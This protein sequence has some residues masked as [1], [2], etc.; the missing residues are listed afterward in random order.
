MNR[1][2]LRGVKHIFQ[3][4]FIQYIKSKSY[5]II[6]AVLIIASIVS[7]PLISIITSK[8]D[9]KKESVDIK[10]ILIVGGDENWIRGFQTI[11]EQ[12][13]LLK[14]VTLV[15]SDET[16]EK[17][18]K[19]MEQTDKRLEY[20]L[21]SVNPIA[22]S[23]EVIYSNVLKEDGV[24]VYDVLMMD[25]QKLQ[26]AMSGL[27]EQ[28]CELLNK[29][30]YINY[31]DETG[32]EEEIFFSDFDYGVTYA[33]SIVLMLFTVFSS[34]S[35]AMS[36]VTE[37]S[38]KVVEYLMVSVKPLALIIGKVFAVICSIA[39]EFAAVGVSLII[40]MIINGFMFPNTDGS[41]AMPEFFGVVEEFGN[42]SGMTPLNIIVAVL[43]ILAGI[44]VYGLLAG[45]MGATVSKIEEAAEGM[46]LYTIALLVG[47]YMVYGYVNTIQ[48]GG[49]WGALDKLPHLLPLSSPFMMPQFL[50]LG[51]TTLQ[52]AL[53]SL[54]I[55][56][57]TALL[58]MRF[59][60]VVYEYL[61]YHRGETVKL[62]QLI[63]L[64]KMNKKKR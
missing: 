2:S 35:V 21:I 8:L 63:S 32:E 23:V 36:I 11:F 52:M 15:Q 34:E 40:S 64:Y 51:E 44:L 39:I 1:D 48:G 3:F 24:Y 41:F 47:I 12:D 56:I 30:I 10:K 33:F 45:L 17:L 53:G 7:F 4:S 25:S 50:L 26:Y 20:I 5:R 16:A 38:T 13:E 6:T 19:E 61:I 55:L 46:K 18:E 14:N 60:A 37:K 54:A 59:A 29:E 27:S 57:V 31:Y 9:N 43:I 49:N 28:Q 58:L 22:N 62:K 42:A